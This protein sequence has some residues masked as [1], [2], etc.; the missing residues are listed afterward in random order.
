VEKVEL[1]LKQGKTVDEIEKELKSVLGE[2]EIAKGGLNAILQS[3]KIAPVKG[4]RAELELLSMIYEAFLA[5]KN[6]SVEPLGGPDATDVIVKFLYQDLEIGRVLIE[7]KA[8]ERWNNAFLEQIQKDMRRYGIATAILS[9]LKLPRGAKVEAYTVDDTLG[10]VVITTPEM[11]ISN[12]TM[13]YDIYL[14]NY[15]LG[16]RT[17]NLQAIMDDRDIVYHI[18]DNLECLNDCKKIKDC[19]DKSQ[20]A[21]HNHVPNIANRLKNNNEKIALILSEHWKNVAH[22]SQSS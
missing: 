3:F 18:N 12:L 19:V 6:V 16:R 13:F 2:L 8:S 21:I 4:E 15:R 9:V 11:A 7:S 10:L 1:L 17:I 5:N 14:A 20:R 22:R